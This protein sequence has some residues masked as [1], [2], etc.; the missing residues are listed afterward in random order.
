MR[1]PTETKVKAGTGGAGAGAV[2]GETINWALDVYLFTGAGEGVPSPVS[3]L[4]LL[5]CSAAVAYVAGRSAPHTL[6]SDP[7]AMAASSRH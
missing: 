1:I 4:V 3:T 7:A 5:V 6:R 2:L